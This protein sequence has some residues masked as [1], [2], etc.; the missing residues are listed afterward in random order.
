ML[1]LSKDPGGGE[2]T[3]GLCNIQHRVTNCDSQSESVER[4]GWTH[5]DGE[6]RQTLLKTAKCL[7]NEQPAM[8][9]MLIFL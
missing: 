1:S 6:K 9:S 4:A 8:W 2:K 3:P 7:S 5:A